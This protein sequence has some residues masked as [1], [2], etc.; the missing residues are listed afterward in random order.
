[1]DDEFNDTQGTQVWSHICCAVYYHQRIDCIRRNHLM[2]YIEA[3]NVMICTCPLVPWATEASP[4][5][6]R[7]PGPG[8]V[9]DRTRVEG[10]GGGTA[11]RP[12]AFP[13]HRRRACACHAAG[14][15][16]EWTLC[17]GQRPWIETV[18]KTC[19]DIRYISLVPVSSSP[20]TFLRRCMPR[21]ISKIKKTRSVS[22]SF[23]HL[24]DG[25]RVPT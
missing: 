24:H 8:A 4:A 11:A 23:T 6:R 21:R 16:G 13:F 19:T 20:R 10:R 1:M 22:A 15:R 17:Q 9:R 3:R 25:C 12:S 7:V 14:G 5:F 2:I 18:Q